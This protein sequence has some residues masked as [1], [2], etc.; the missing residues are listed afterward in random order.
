MNLISESS[1]QAYDHV[2]DKVMG[3]RA[4]RTAR[5]VRGSIPIMAADSAR[6]SLD[7]I[8][9]HHSL[10]YD[11]SLESHNMV[12]SVF[13]NSV[14]IHQLASDRLVPAS[15]FLFT[16][17]GV[18]LHSHATQ[19]ASCAT[20]PSTSLRPYI[21]SLPPTEYPVAQAA[22]LTNPLIALTA[23]PSFAFNNSVAFPLLKSNSS[24][25]NVT[26]A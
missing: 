10:H 5:E 26:S 14:D 9:H 22:A 24:T 3:L 12:P 1:D 8:A 23:S 16:G 17:S 4:N 6:T 20:D 13:F 18:R 19:P 11:Y 25:N 7:E 21:L 2:V 15:G